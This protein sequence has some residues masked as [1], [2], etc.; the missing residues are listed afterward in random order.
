MMKVFIA[1]EALNNLT[2]TQLAEKYGGELVEPFNQGGSRDSKPYFLFAENDKGS[3]FM[4]G[5]QSWGTGVEC[6]FQED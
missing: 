6:T 1:R 2:V 4:G 5:L 3:A